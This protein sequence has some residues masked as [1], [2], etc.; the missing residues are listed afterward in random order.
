LL[1]ET[2]A[3]LRSENHNRPTKTI[4]DILVRKKR[5]KRGAINRSTLDRYLATKG[6]SRRMLHKVG[7]KVF[8]KIATHAPLELVIADFHHGPYVKVPG[9]DRARK[10]YC[11]SS[12]TISAATFWI[13]ATIYTK[14]L[15]YCGSA[16]VASC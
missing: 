1:L 6:L 12:L 3:G 2:A 10:S 15:L 7:K 16:F 9:E 13:L 8:K 5:V 4:I 14:T 11:W